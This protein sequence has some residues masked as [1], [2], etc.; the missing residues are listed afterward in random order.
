MNKQ[1]AIRALEMANCGVQDSGVRSVVPVYNGNNHPVTIILWNKSQ[2]IIPAYE[3][4]NVNL[5]Q[6]AEVLWQ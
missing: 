4:R 1:H 6:I 3:S 2:I 5:E